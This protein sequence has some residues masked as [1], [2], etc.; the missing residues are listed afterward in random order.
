MTWANV[1]VAAAILGPLPPAGFARAAGTPV[2]GFTLE[3][4]RGK[5]HSLDDLAGE[6]LV[7]IAFLGTECPLAKLY[8]PRLA[9]LH[10]AYGPRGVAFVAINSN[11]HDSLAEIAASARAHGLEFP[12]LK[13]P[14]NQVADQFGAT[15]TPEVF[16]LDRDRVIRYSGRID[17]QYGVGYVR[18][19]PGRNELADALDELLA[20]KSVTRPRADPVGCLIGRVRKPEAGATVTYSNR[21]AHILGDRCV[22]CHR[23]GD[24]A[25]FA[26][27]TYDEAAGWAEMIAEVVRDQRMPPWHASGEFGSFH[28]DR[29]LSDDDKNA[30]EQ[31]AKD[32]APEGDPAGLPAA[33]TFVEGWQLPQ[34]PDLVL[35]IQAE[36][37]RIQAEGEV[38]YQ[39][40]IVD[41]G[42]TADTWIKG[43]EIVPGNRAVVHHILAFVRMP[44]DAIGI[45]EGKGYFAGY[46]PGVRADALPDGMARLVPAGARLAFQ[47]HYTPIGTVQEDLSRIG[48]VF[49]DPATITHRVVS[50]SALQRDLEI[51][52]REA[53]YR[54]E[55]KSRRI[56]WSTLLLSMSPHMHL[57]GKTIRY[58]AEYPDGTREVL[59]DVPRYDFNWQTEYRLTNPLTLPPGTRI[60]AVAHFDNSA[61]NPSN[62]DP[63]KTV[64]WG[65]QSWDE[66]MIGYF[67]IA[68]PAD[69]EIAVPESDLRGPAEVAADS[70]RKTRKMFRRLDANGDAALTIGEVPLAMKAAFWSTDKDGS[71]TVSEEEF[72]AVVAEYLKTQRPAKVPKPSSAAPGGE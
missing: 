28:N 15:R 27:T 33:K 26:L 35:P 32:G 31:W 2:A 20:G 61:T 67:T 71:G 50:S 30:I 39:W 13:D 5:Q 46:V 11:G 56:P 22:E 29:S 69:M 53:N 47:V 36:P 3:D 38:A 18:E 12:V 60:H 34:P 62:P 6:Q 10:Q 14:G 23:G 9:R 19:K 7:V 70:E 45:G 59:L 1:A 57:R 8:S 16:V 65:D 64:S 63:N 4:V 48:L 55:A 49:A 66:M 72:V 37:F 58:E 25:P 17:D 43:V 54:A 40:F 42:F 52:A 24:I 21:I 44:D 51:P 68:V 41:P